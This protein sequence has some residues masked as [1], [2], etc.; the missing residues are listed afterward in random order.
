[1]RWR[2]NFGNGQVHE[3]ASRRACEALIAAQIGGPRGAFI[4]RY[5][6]DDAPGGWIR[7]RVR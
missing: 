4:Q 1:M 6:G 2:V 3:C 5:V 7:V